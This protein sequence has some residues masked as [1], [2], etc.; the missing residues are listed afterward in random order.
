MVVGFILGYFVAVA[1]LEPGHAPVL[2]QTQASGGQLPEGHPPAELMEM[3]QRLM[4]RAQADPEDSEVRALLG[5]AYYDMQRFSNA[6]EW[7]EAAIAL[8]PE[9]INV[10]TDLGTSYYYTGDA[11]RAIERFNES[12]R[13]DANHAQTLQNLGVVLASKGDLA[14]AIEAWQKLIEKNPDYPHSDQ[15]LQQIE[16]A[17]AGLGGGES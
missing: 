14:E 12:L 6:I 15:I 13:L 8:D 7:Y 1:S 17:R 11:D 3:V 10:S 2:Q 5:N 16:K 4:E 9:N